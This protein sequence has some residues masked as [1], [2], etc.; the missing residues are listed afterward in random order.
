MK[1]IPNKNNKLTV[2][3]RSEADFDKC[4]V[5]YTECTSEHV[6]CKSSTEC[7]LHKQIKTRSKNFELSIIQDSEASSGSYQLLDNTPSRSD[8]EHTQSLQTRNNGRFRMTENCHPKAF[9]GRHPEG[10]TRRTYSESIENKE[11]LRSYSFPQNDGESNKINCHPELVSG[12]EQTAQIVKKTAES[13]NNNLLEQTSR[14]PS[15]MVQMLNQVQH[16]GMIAAL[17]LALSFFIAA[18]AMAADT[19][20]VPASAQTDNSAYTLTKVDQPGTN[21]ITKY[22]GS[23]TENKLVPQYYQVNLNKTEDG[24]PDVADETKTFTVTT[25]NPEGSSNAFEYEIKYYVDSSRLA[26]ERITED[27]QGANIDNDFVGLNSS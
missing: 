7:D 12:S 20:P 21:V 9:S 26:P 10:E 8:S 15:K 11:I 18:P 1:K 3:L 24:Y 14:Q 19:P 25:P 6:L 17:T 4:E 13:E 22:E 23:D 2:I 5:E 16:D 27:L